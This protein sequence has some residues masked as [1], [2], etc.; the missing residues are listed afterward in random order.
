MS[1][2]E[3]IT[4]YYEFNLVDIEKHYNLWHTAMAK[5]CRNDIIAYSIKA[6]YGARI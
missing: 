4:P 5:R 2:N 6:N 3:K 1:T